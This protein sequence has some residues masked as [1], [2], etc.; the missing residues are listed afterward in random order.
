MKESRKNKANFFSYH[1]MYLRNVQNPR[2]KALD[3][4]FWLLTRQFC[5]YIKVIDDLPLK[6]LHSSRHMVS[7]FGRPVHV[8]VNREVIVYV[9]STEEV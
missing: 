1:T 6:N 5:I 7:L 9:G 3:L 4:C 2:I 8:I